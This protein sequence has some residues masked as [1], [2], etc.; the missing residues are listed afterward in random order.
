MI[1]PISANTC[2]ESWLV[3]ANLLNSLPGRYAYNLILDIESPTITTPSDHNIV[4]TVDRFLNS[5]D[6][7]AIATVAE[8]IFPLACYQQHGRR[9]VFED[10]PEKIYPKLTKN[11]GTYAGRMMV[12]ESRRGERINPLEIVIQKFKQQVVL[13]SSLRSAYEL[14][15]ADVFADLPIHDPA[16]DVRRTLN[17]P[18]LVHLSF[19]LREHNG[20][21]LTA[22]YRSHYYVQRTLGNLIGL[23]QLLSFV[24]DEAGL[25][26]EGMVCH[27]TFARLETVGGW[28]RRQIDK[29]LAD[30]NRLANIGVKTSAAGTSSTC[31]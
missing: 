12:R 1:Y 27:S 25:K 26:A 3:A 5:H 18:C 23:A 24:A 22:L 30:C 20:I 17:Q 11:W 4:R 13:R 2:A 14:S 16:F 10:F 28:N 31:H 15:L 7:D 29:L 19:K 8:T 6:G 9:G 21:M